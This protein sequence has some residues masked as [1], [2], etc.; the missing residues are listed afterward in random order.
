MF[1]DYGTPTP[2]GAIRE[3]W[4]Y[5]LTTPLEVGRLHAQ[6]AAQGIVWGEGMQADFVASAAGVW[7]STRGLFGAVGFG[8]ATPG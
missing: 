7:K 6:Q 5:G 1:D 8:P 3:T 2:A 4:R